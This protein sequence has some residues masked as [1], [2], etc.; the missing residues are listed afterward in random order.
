MGKGDNVRK[1]NGKIY[2]PTG[3]HGTKSQCQGEA[4]IWKNKGYLTRVI[5]VSAKHKEY[6]LWFRGR[7]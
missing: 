3:Y 6:G 2:H 5:R 1:F 4:N 7:R